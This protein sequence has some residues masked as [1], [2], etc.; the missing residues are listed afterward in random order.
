MIIE[1]FNNFIAHANATTVA[2]AIPAAVVL[3]HVIPWLMDSHSIR[4]YPGP[5]LAKFTDFWLAF[6]SRGGRRS[7]IIHDYHMKYGM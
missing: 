4:K 5:F 1:S 6:T 7:E 2:C 3:F